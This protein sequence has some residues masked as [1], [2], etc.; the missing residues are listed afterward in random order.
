MHKPV[1][2]IDCL[3]ISYS[4]IGTYI[5][6]ILPGLIQSDRFSIICLG[7]EELK[8]YNW[9]NQ[10][11]FIELKSSI[12]SIKEQFELY[13]KTP[14]C[15]IF[16]TPNWNICFLP[17]RVK[18]RIITIHDV[19]HLAQKKQVPFL[20]YVVVKAI[21]NVAVQYADKIITVSEFSKN[22][23]QK[24]LYINGTKIVVSY[25]AVSKVFNENFIHKVN[26]EKYLLFV[27]NV[28][29]NKNIESAIKAYL[30]IKNPEYKFYIV[31]DTSTMIS[32]CPNIIKL[33]EGVESQIIFKGRVNNEALKNYY[34]NAKGFIF[35][36]IYEGFGFPVLEAMK[37]NLP[38]AA[39]NT[40]AIPEAGGDCIEYFN[41]FDIQE[42]ADKI[43]RIMGNN[44][45]VDID[46]YLHQI[47]KFDWS[48][49][50][51][52]HINFLNL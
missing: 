40:S 42:I 12:F 47:N 21:I 16:W 13:R 18:R 39:S 44:Y 9:I 19:Y 26:N 50:V 25:S 4:G 35:P 46:A 38:I 17:L 32:E 34:A 48:K 15:D 31:G 20:K 33:L 30:L 43:A 51:I 23:I 36:S 7:Y 8:Q 52:N 22:E 3:M 10:A 28:K 37:F 6:N 14:K 1:L 29:R 45:S 2:A 5:Q 24:Y 41:P 11:Q 27:G 49:T